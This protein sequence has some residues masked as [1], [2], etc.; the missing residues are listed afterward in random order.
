M[1]G[2]GLLCD[3]ALARKLRGGAGADKDTLRAFLDE[4]YQGYCQDFGSAPNAVRRMQELWTYL[5]CLFEE[6]G[7]HRKQLR[8]AKHAAEYEAAVA[9]IFRELELQAQGAGSQ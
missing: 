3:P 2:R 4:L 1:L 7:R 5:L 9:T 8:K 6:S